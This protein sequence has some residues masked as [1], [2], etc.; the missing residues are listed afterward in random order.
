MTLGLFINICFPLCHHA[1]LVGS[2]KLKTNAAGLASHWGP[3]GRGRG[4][5]HSKQITVDINED[6]ADA[7]DG[8][9]TKASFSREQISKD[10]VSVSCLL[11]FYWT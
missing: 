2:W 11:V 5:R 1:P 9:E 7:V 10:K 8:S 6:D 4:V 3:E